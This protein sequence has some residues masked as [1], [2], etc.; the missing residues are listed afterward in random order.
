MDKITLEEM[1][2]NGKFPAYAWP[3]G[4]PIFYLANDGE[5]LCPDCVNDSKNPIHADLPNDGWRIVARDVNWEDP[6]LFCAHCNRR[7][8]S[9]YAEDKAEGI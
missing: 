5:A 2:E 4:Y 8:E 9:A 1:K 6:E 3:G 7:I